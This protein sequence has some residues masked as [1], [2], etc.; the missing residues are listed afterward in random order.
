MKKYIAVFLALAIT[1]IPLTAQDLSLPELVNQGLAALKEGDWEKAA[2]LNGEAVTQ[3][4]DDPLKALQLHG[5]QFGVIHFR[6]GIAQLKLEQYAEAMASFEA[7]YSQFPNEEGA[8]NKNV[9]NKLALLKWGEAAMGAGDHQLA[10]TQWNKFIEERDRVKDRY[11]R[12]PFHVNMAISHFKLKQIAEGTEQLE[13]AIANRLTFPTPDNAILAGF[14]AF[15]AAAIEAKDEQLLVDFIKKNRGALTTPPYEMQRYSNLYMKLAGDAI[16]AEMYRTALALYQFVPATSISIDAL[17]A[18]IESMGALPRITDGSDRI[19]KETLEKDLDALQEE[20]RGNKTIEMIKLAA[21][22]FIHERLGNVT[23]AYAAYLQLENEHPRAETREENLFHLFRTASLLAYDESALKYGNLMR[24]TFPASKHIQDVQKLL[25]SQLFFE[26]AYQRTISMAKEMLDTGTVPENTPEH[27]LATFVYAGSNF[28]LG[29]YDA[30]DPLLEKHA[31]QYPDSQFAMSTDY[32]LASNASRLQ[33]WTKAASLLDKFLAKYEDDPD[34]SYI[35]LALYDRA[36]AHYAEE[37]AEGA[38]EKVN[39][40]VEKF[41][42][43]PVL[44]QAYNLLG[45]VYQSEGEEEAAEEAYIKAL[46]IA[47][48][49]G[50]SEVAAEALNYLVSMLGNPDGNRLAEAIPYADKFWEKFSEGSAYQ[51]QVA[52]SQ[53]AALNAADRNEDALERLQQVISN[54]AK[55]Q[56]APGLEEAINSYTEVYLETHSPDELKEHY[57]S[58]PGIGTQ[59]KAARALLRIA[60]IGV[61]E[62]VAKSAEDPDKK[63]AANAGIQVLFSELKSDFDLKDLSNYI[64][65]KLGDYLRTNTSTPTEALPYYD[66]AISRQDQAYRFGAL[67]GRADVYGRSDSSEDLSRAI[68]DFERIIADSQEA[69]DREFALFRIIEILM[70]QKKYAEAAERANRYLNRDPAAG[71]VL[72]FTT[73]SA[74]VGLMLAKSFEERDMIDDAISM[75]VKVWSAHMGNIG[76]AAPAVEAWM[77]LSYSRNKKSSDPKVPADRQGAYNG[78]WRFLDL[79][80]RFKDKLTPEE[81]TA[82]KRVEELVAEYLANPDVKSMEQQN[83]EKAAAESRR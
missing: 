19:V 66:E 28:Y 59:D 20:A 6:R 31:E 60:I 69:A 47:E 57:Y 49:N 1:A 17:K 55:L 51:A 68:G 25:L 44:D 24:K 53:V 30:A 16:G 15:T 9:F 56:R 10:I 64:L 32:F 79:T 80:E 40:L 67:I 33:Y 74:E 3:Y 41:P 43:A 50:R 2:Q 83:E 37:Q 65:V 76:V 81:A 8:K 78:G 26:G 35:P 62:G 11:P 5:P 82:R 29:N 23:G 34:Q 63:R 22:A 4:G 38:K 7:C 39:L 52:V 77:K 72:N 48:Q 21:T 36:S 45:N 42:D 61:F 58:F 18:K 75:Y 73:Y 27:D 46:E 71:D 13:I 54:I 14:Q 12:G 70:K